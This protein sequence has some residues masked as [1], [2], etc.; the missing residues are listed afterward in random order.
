MVANI[1]NNILEQ[2]NQQPNSEEI[3]KL[4]LLKLEME[5]TRCVWKEPR[6]T[7]KDASFVEIVSD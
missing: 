4:L 7:H 5:V 2:I 3:K 6:S 1:V